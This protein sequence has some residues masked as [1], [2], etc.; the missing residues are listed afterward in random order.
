L[1]SRL[2]RILVP[3]RISDGFTLALA[4]VVLGV[5]LIG[6]SSLGLAVQIYRNNDVLSR[7]Y[8]HILALDQVHSV[9]DDLIFELQQMDATGSF[10]RTA[11]ADA[12]H[13]DFVRQLEIVA[14]IHR[15]ERPL[16]AS[17]E[18]GLVDRLRRLGDDLQTL[19]HETA[20]RASSPQRLDRPDL[21]RLNR[22]S[23]EVPRVVEELVS[24]HRLRIARLLQ[25]SQGMIRGIVALYVA[26]ILV[27][28][29]L[30]AVASVVSRR[31]ITAPLHSL[32]EAALA[33]A[34]GRL[35]ARV[36]VASPSEIGDL[37]DA[38]NSMA[39]GLQSRQAQLEAARD[40]LE[41]KIREVGALY[42]IG[43]EIS[44][45]HQ[46]E[47]ILQS[48]VDRARELLQC[49]AASLCLHGS[50]DGGL[51]ARATSGPPEAFHPGTEIVCEGLAASGSSSVASPPCPAVQ[52]AFRQGH[53][54]A[55]LR[56]GD[57]RVGEIHVC[58]HEPREFTA[59]EAEL[60]DGLATQAAIAIE[61]SRLADEVRGLATVQERERLAREMHDGFAQTLGVLHMRLRHAQSHVSDPA[62][63]DQELVEMSE[64][65]R[66]AY[67][68][69]RQ[70]IFGLRTFV[71]RGLG[72]VPTLTE[73]LHEFSAQNGIAV[74]LE[75]AS[76][77]LQ[78]TP[79]SEVQAIRII[80]EALN[81]VR[82]HASAHRAWVRLRRENGRLLVTVEDDGVGWGSEQSE[83]RDRL[84]FGLQTM[85][86]RA[87]SLGGTLEID[88]GPGRGT[89]VMASLPT[90]AT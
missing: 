7:E 4:L 47:R 13:E 83:S 75:V 25:E 29:S 56:L 36:R 49:D 72:L 89:R 30:V 46:R 2:G 59:W 77:S 5:L 58:S 40:H 32:S 67:E 73:Y 43:T 62:S 71:A 57:L 16:R 78:L 31:K 79:V 54:S 23:H 8:G 66:R 45:L 42:R 90:E 9:L 3:T 22:T 44:R 15:E 19:A 10:D 11:E 14:T 82:K 55:A 1:S 17:R 34:E 69:V 74:D 81:N 88:T 85:R 21:D 70:S 37:S 87:A 18:Q 12:M 64:I 84:H 80:Q 35:D 53:L 24:L 68:E 52:P 6:G 41:Q 48:V 61:R 65:T 39:E 33:I 50:G 27:S 60:L 28:G 76:P 20:E 38:F 86:E 26:F 63:L 51:A